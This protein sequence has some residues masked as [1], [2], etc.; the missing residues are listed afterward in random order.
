MLR[1]RCGRGECGGRGWCGA[2]SWP[3]P[4]AEHTR[5][6]SLSRTGCPL[7][8][9]QP[10][11]GPETWTPWT[12]W[13]CGPASG[14]T[15]NRPGKLSERIFSTIRIVETI[16]MLSHIIILSK[17]SRIFSFD[18]ISKSIYIRYFEF[19]HHLLFV[20]TKSLGTLSSTTSTT[21]G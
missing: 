15:T 2:R 16:K 17:I 12:A 5:A 11:G 9:R 3:V 1:T 8:T 4:G 19:G 10:G 20:P 18:Q 7:C 14:E 13:T 6:S 21:R